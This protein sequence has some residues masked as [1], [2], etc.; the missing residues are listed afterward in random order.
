MASLVKL[1]PNGL[2]ARDP[3]AL[4]EHLR[5]GTLGE[6]APGDPILVVLRCEGC[7]ERRYFYVPEERVADPP[8]YEA[9]LIGMGWRALC[10][11]DCANREANRGPDR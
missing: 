8:A 3:R 6:P 1:G 11:P 2:I 10:C 4:D 7:H 5:Y 9:W